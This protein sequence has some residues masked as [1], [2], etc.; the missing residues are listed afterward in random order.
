[1]AKFESEVKK[2]NASADVVY[3]FISNF[4][5]FQHLIPKD[6]IT[7]WE[8]DDDSCSFKVEGLGE[9]GLKIIDKEENKTLKYTAQGKVPFDFYLW[10]QLKEVS[11]N[12]TCVKLTIKADMNPMMKMMASKHVKTFLNMLGDAIVNYNYELTQS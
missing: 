3:G 12:D 6:K 8:S 11:N 4:N 5:N 2:A 7:D 10:I 9:A 1:M